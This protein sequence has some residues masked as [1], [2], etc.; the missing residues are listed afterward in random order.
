MRV[1]D[2]HVLG[3]KAEAYVVPLLR[4]GAW[5]QTGYELMPAA[6]D[7]VV[8]WSY[9]PIDPWCLAFTTGVRPDEV[10]VAGET[11][12]KDGAP[13]RVDAAEVRAKAAEQAKRLFQRLEDL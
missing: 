3:G 12:W 4:A 13:T 5:L 1:E 6:R 7:D 8:T 10:V 11:V 2:V 9:E